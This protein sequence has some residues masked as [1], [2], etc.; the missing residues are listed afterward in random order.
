M[1]LK[2]NDMLKHL[3][4]RVQL[5]C[6]TLQFRVIQA[7]VFFSRE[8]TFMPSRSAVIQCLL[9]ESIKKTKSH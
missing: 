9:K 3:P 4:F 1:H 7:H 8:L 6:T 5:F 2:K